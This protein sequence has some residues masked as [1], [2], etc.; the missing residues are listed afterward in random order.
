MKYYLISLIAFLTLSGGIFAQVELAK[1]PEAKKILDRVSQKN[2]SFANLRIK[3]TYKVENNQTGKEENF[4]GYAFLSGKKYKIIIPGNELI[5]DG[6]TVWTYMKE[7][8]E[9]TITNAEN[10]EESIFN[11]MKLFTAYE[12][13]YKYLLIGEETIDSKQYHVIDLFPELNETSPYSKIRLKINTQ[14][15]LIYAFETYEKSGVNYYITVSEYK[16]DIKIADKLFVFDQ[17]KY[18]ADIE[19]VDLR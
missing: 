1:D 6:I 19:I 18:P 16:S 17:S 5:S 10:D 13:G 4:K 15:D 2:K 14:T 3:Y 9:V 7:S 12:S 11:P 8:A